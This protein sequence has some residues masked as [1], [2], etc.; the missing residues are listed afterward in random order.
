[1]DLTRLLYRAKSV[2]H[3][4]RRHAADMEIPL[5][6]PLRE[7]STE[8]QQ[9]VRRVQVDLLWRNAP[10]GYAANVLVAL[11]VMLTLSE[12]LTPAVQLWFFGVLAVTLIRAVSSYFYFSAP[13]HE[14]DAARWGKV[15]IGLTFMTGMTWGVLGGFLYPMTDQY[16]QSLI[17][18]V[19]VGITAGAVVT[20]GFVATAYYVYLGTALAPYVLRVFGG[21]ERF[22]VPLGVLAVIYAGFMVV[23]ARRTSH[24][25]VSNLVSIHQLEQTTR[26]LNRAQ[27]D[28]LTGLPTRGLLYDRLDQAVLRAE[29]THKLLAVLFIDLDGFKE[30][31]DTLGH[32]AGDEAL[33]QL[34]QRFKETVR[35]ED[36][37]A[38]HGGDEF[39]LVLGDINAPADVEPI[40]RKL[41]AHIAALQIGSD[42]TRMLTGSIGAAFYPHD[43]KRGGDLI[44]RADAAMYR[45]KQEG[46]NAY[47]LSSGEAHPSAAGVGS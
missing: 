29:R 5:E 36:T 17:V 20:T 44:T 7:L 45:A 47:A 31:N 28:Q 2:I 30:I 33:R 40:A 15:F 41:L 38:R 34:A 1:M 24:N 25:L 12:T 4:Y 46:K 27:H 22:D 23:A 8:L 39:V 3:G 42:R 21:D 18:V 35:A 13:R 14:V 11:A 16:G 43:A 10:A 26:E 19:V 9:S 37:V 6:R 32:D